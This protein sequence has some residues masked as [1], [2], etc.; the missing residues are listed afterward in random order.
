MASCRAF[1]TADPQPLLSG[2]LTT[3]N[4]KE[5]ASLPCMA[6]RGDRAEVGQFASDGEGATNQGQQIRKDEGIAKLG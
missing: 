5:D 2:T 4:N 3:K 1:H 6:G